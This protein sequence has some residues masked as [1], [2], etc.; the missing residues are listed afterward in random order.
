MD[1]EPL[2]G[3]MVGPQ[4]ATPIDDDDDDDDDT[5]PLPLDRGTA[6]LHTRVQGHPQGLSLRS[7]YV[8]PRYR[9]TSRF[10]WSPHSNYIR[11]KPA[12]VSAPH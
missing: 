10:V 8:D 1:D 12:R 2:P 9:S 7:V 6:S 11:E 4:R 5:R 3:E